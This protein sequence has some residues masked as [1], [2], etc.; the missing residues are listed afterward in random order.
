M[1][2][3][4]RG[5]SEYL[6]AKAEQCFRLADH[7]RGDHPSSEVAAELDAIAHEFLARAVEVDTERDRVETAKQRQQ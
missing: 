5:E 2:M 4:Q 6:I 1:E 7:I 3:P